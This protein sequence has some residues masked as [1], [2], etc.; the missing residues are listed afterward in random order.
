MSLRVV[1]AIGFLWLC[2]G[3]TRL[4]AAQL[5]GVAGGGIYGGIPRPGRSSIPT[6]SH[7]PPDE[8]FDPG[9]LAHIRTFCV[10]LGNMES[11][12]TAGVK[13]FLAEASEPGKVLDRLPWQ[14]VE[15]CTKADAVARIYFGATGAIP[16]LLLYDKASIRLFYRAEG[17][18]FRGNPQKALATPFAMLAKDL[19]KI[20]GH[21]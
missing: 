1:A 3:Q 4:A 13:G 5:P 14:R 8:I 21:T 2:C 11:W 6:I 15:D 16:V 9:A 19:K 18:V 10:D 12:Q 20:K 7:I 17:Q